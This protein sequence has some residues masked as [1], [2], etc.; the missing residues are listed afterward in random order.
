MWRPYVRAIKT[1]FP[2]IALV[3]DAFHILA[4]YSRMLDALRTQEYNN[5]TGP[6]RKIIKGTRFLLLRGQE[7]LSIPAKEKLQ[8]LQ[9]TVGNYEQNVPE[10]RELGEF[11]QKIANLMN[12][13]NLVEQVIE[14][15]RE[16][17]ADQLNCIPVDMECKGRLTEIFAF[18]KS[19]Q[20]MDR[21]VRIESIK[22][23]NDRD[24][25]GEVSMQTKVV[26]YYRP[27]PEKA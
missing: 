23:V 4:D 3:Y 10:H 1:R 27:Q 16:I 20:S 18:Y 25:S 7:K 13:H 22:L 5:L 11:L 21:L 24:F 26:I 17:E 2:Q 15:A 19:L 6:M 9:Q 12:E 8:K 14:P